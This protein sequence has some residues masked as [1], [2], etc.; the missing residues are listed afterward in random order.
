MLLD[1]W[2]IEFTKLPAER[3]KI[4]V[5]QLLSTEKQCPVPMPGALD[6][7]ELSIAYLGEVDVGDFSADRRSQRAY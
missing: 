6:L 5:R 7:R 4:V 1:G 3:E 2:R